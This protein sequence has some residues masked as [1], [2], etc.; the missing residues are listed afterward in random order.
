MKGLY[1]IVKMK[2]ILIM[3]LLSSCIFLSAVYSHAA[4]KYWIGGSSWWDYGTN[5]NPAGQPING[6][7]VYLTQS[8]ATDR[9][10]YY[11]NTA[12]PSAVLNSLR[13]DATGTGTMTLK[14]GLD[15]P[16]ASNYEYVGYNGTG[17][18]IQNNGSNSITHDLHL[19]VGSSSFGTYELNEGSLSANKS[20]IG[21]SGTGTFNQS[22]G[23]HTVADSLY[24]A[25]GA[26]A[27][28]T[29]NLSG[30]GSLS[31]NK[32]YIGDSGTG[33]FNHS[34]GSHTVAD[35]LYLGKDTIATGTYNL[36]GSGS[37]SANTE[38]LG[39]N[40]TGFFIQ[41]TGSNTVT[42]NLY[43]GD[44]LSSFGTYELNGGSLSANKIYIGNYGTGTFNH[45]GGTNTVADILN[46]GN[47]NDI[48]INATGT[49]NLSGSGSL[50]ANTENIGGGGSGT[51]NQSGGTNT[52][53]N[54]LNINSYSSE[55]GT[56]ELSDGS[57]NATNEKI[58]L[59][60]KGTFKQS[61]GT[62][63]TN[64]LKIGLHSSDGS[65]EH[66][67]VGT[68]ILSNGSLNAINETIGYQGI[69]TFIQSGGTNTV[70]NDLIIAIYSAILG[71]YVISGGILEAGSIKNNDEFE[72]SGGTVNSSIDNKGTFS[73]TA[74]DLNGQLVND[75]SAYLNGDFYASN[76]MINNNLV[77][78]GTGS[79]LILNGYGL[80]NNGTMYLYGTLFGN[81]PQV[82]NG[83][84][85]VNGRIG[86][87]GGFTNNAILTQGSGNIILNNTGT[88][89]N[90]GLMTLANGY[91]L[92][93]DGGDL[94]NSGSLN[95]NDA[96]V[97]GAATLN[98]T[99]G[100]TVSGQGI[101][102]SGFNNNG[103]RLLVDSSTTVSK[104]FNNSGSI[105]L[106]SNI[107]NLAGGAITNTGS[108]QG[109]GQIGNNV[110]NSGTIEA[111]GGTLTMGGTISNTSS[112]LITASTG[113]K[114][115]MSRG[116]TS[117]DGV[118]NLTGGIFDNNN[119]TMTNS[120][121]M[122]GYGTFRTGGLNN[123]GIITL[124]GGT[125]TVNGGVTNQAAG[126]IEVAYNPAIFT[127]DVINNGFFKT[128]DTTVK[129]A[130]SYTENGIFLSDPSNNYFYDWIIGET[131][132]V[133]GGVGD[134]FFV[135]RNFINNSFQNSLWDTDEAA[136][137]LNGIGQEMYLAGADYGALPSGYDD[138]FAWGS[139]TLRSNVTLSIF[140][141]NSTDGAALYVGVFGLEGGLDQLLK[142]YSDYNIYYKPTLAGND[143]LGG[144]T[145]NFNGN[146]VLAPASSVPIPSGL[147]LLAS[148]LLGL[149]S[150]KR[151]GKTD[152]C[153][154]SRFRNSFLYK[155]I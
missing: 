71:K 140:D 59:Y 113:N 1:S 133:I 130:G 54:I 79:F 30:S 149:I 82:N 33:T 58:G 32:N 67:G 114:L 14:T 6:D 8:D 21:N 37:L 96:I 39:Y 4:D 147:L 91:K 87:N 2:I 88:N 22:G 69:G 95:L 85:Y 51:F 57:L 45:S 128:T 148:G 105:Q 119:H 12:Y 41:N 68:Y 107:S 66:S 40:G 146:G 64:D 13:I 151:R 27:T 102:L 17:F 101:I 153:K 44:G 141:G 154:D 34:G 10:V 111:M 121:Q 70:A 16:L 83:Q 122:S 80:E 120:N 152:K 65:V 86:G 47:N 15:H 53:A 55:G 29:Y 132:R 97:N 104:S 117:N 108:I 24:L 94:T 77:S 11:Y 134:N 76:G 99:Y 56:Y 106:A 131:G 23:S 93:L 75:G 81:G 143:W 19:G 35:S 42:Y 127:G 20:Y 110:T 124:T 7:N 123:Q 52:V 84:M 139:F 61:G 116:L 144:L 136:L 109:V 3:V 28:G 9:I 98:N 100:G 43:I 46:L 118:I 103:G 89:A 60:A 125:T 50:F 115:L 5:W 36:S 38:Y 31:V 78:T 155:N 137:I 48:N 72:M 62:N 63:T 126:K 135:L 25:N 73:Y 142:I 26:T 112:G 129:F 74:G 18:F 92:Q 90:K 150:V 138:N 145:Y 49:Y